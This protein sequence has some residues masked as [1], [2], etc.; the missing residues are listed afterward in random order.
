MKDLREGLIGEWL[1]DGDAYDTSG[2][3]NHGTPAGGVSL[4]TDHLGRLNRAYLNDANGED[5]GLQVSMELTGDFTIEFYIDAV[6][7]TGW[8]IWCGAVVDFFGYE[9][10]TEQVRIAA[11]NVIVANWD[12]IL[13]SG[14]THIILSRAGTTH[15]LYID[16]VSKGDVVAAVQPFSVDH[17]MS[18]FNT[19]IWNCKG[20]YERC[21]MWDRALDVN[22]IHQLYTDIK[23]NHQGLF[24]GLIVGYDMIK[25]DTTIWEGVLDWSENSHIGA[26][27]GGTPVV[28]PD[29]FGVVDNA[30]YFDTQP[31]A[32][33]VTELDIASTD[34]ISFEFIYSSDHTFHTNSI[35]GN[36]SSSIGW[37]ITTGGDNGYISFN[38][39]SSFLNGFE[40]RTGDL[41]VDDGNDHHVVV[42][43][44]GS[45]LA[46]GVAIYVDGD[47]APRAVGGNQG[48]LLDTLA[49]TGGIICP[50]GGIFAESLVGTIQHMN[51]WGRSLSAG[52]ARQL[53]DLSMVTTPHS[54]RR[55]I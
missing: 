33:E 50:T 47:Y 38:M 49:N 5:I 13:P 55:D 10:G 6:F 23:G 29:R 9:F 34:P 28:V 15:T 2:G 11:N 52:E 21:R 31:L 12:F 17:I 14:L 3:G 53:Y 22:E 35:I 43:Y 44:D 27:W 7:E 24:D 26:K 18:G 8:N 42:T 51:I 54:Y 37:I 39:F 19:T 32:L 36:V 40:Y 45:K 41:N 20:V 48:T 4:T 1:F 30:I 46:T 25:P 16:G